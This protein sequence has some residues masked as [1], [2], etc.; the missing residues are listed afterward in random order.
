[1]QVLGSSKIIMKT[2]SRTIKTEALVNTNL[3][4]PVLVSWQDLIR[5]KVIDENFPQS[6]EKVHLFLKV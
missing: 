4:H 5:L 2:R 3:A 6:A 1:M